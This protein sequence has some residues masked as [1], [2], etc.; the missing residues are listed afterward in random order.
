MSRLRSRVKIPRT[1]TRVVLLLALVFGVA[2]TFVATVGGSN[3]Y[4]L[5][6]WNPGKIID[7]ATFYDTS[8]FSSVDAIQSFLN[9]KTP[10]CDTWGTQ[11]SE[12][13]GGT[14][15]QYAASRGWHGPPYVCLQNYH[16]NPNTHETSFERGGAGFEGGISAAQIIW[17]VSHEYGI[18]PQVLLVT[19]KKEQGSLYTDSW[20][21]KSQYRYA[22]G[23]GCPDTGPNNSANC[24]DNYAGLYNQLR[25]AAYQFK[26][27][28]TYPDQYGYRAGRSNY[29]Q[30]S[31][32]ASCGGGWVYIENQ[33]T[34]GLYNYTPYQ[35]NSGAI[36]AYPGTAPCGAYGNRNFW[37]FFDEWFGGQYSYTSEKNAITARYQALGSS[38]LGS[39][40]DP[41]YCYAKDGDRW[42][43][44]KYEKGYILSGKYGAWESYGDIRGRWEALNFERGVLGY[45][46]DEV[47]CYVKNGDNWCVQRYEGGYII[48]GK[49]G[50]WESYGDIR[51][52]WADLGYEN[53]T[54]GYPREGVY[55][56]TNNGDR[57]CVQR[58][59]K[60]YI[61]SGKYGAWES[62]GDIRGRW[63]ALNFERGTLGYPREGVY[64][65]TKDGDNKCVQRYEG[66]YIISGKHGAWESHGAIRQRWA[67]LGYENGTLG[68]PREGVYCYTN[69]GDNWCVQRYDNGYILSGKYGAWESH[70]AIRGRWEALNF[71]R[72]VLGYPREG[73]FCYVKRGDNWCVQ[74]YEHG[75]IISG[76]Y[77]AWESYGDMRQ[78]W[79]S[80]GY[81][82]GVLGY[83]T[84]GVTVVPSGLSQ[85]YEGGTLFYRTST[86]SVEVTLK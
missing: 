33:A 48:S 49:Y 72:G 11:Q 83:P 32:D 58:Y 68:Y 60:G 13:G 51:G 17:N 81:E 39:A 20:P 56:Y 62:Y 45:P 43:V 2:T 27:Y 54:L 79:A 19:L 23:Y 67:D 75:Y 64:C 85:T 18:N 53:G 29:I 42:C 35:P 82:N 3:T 12:Y 80:L 25:L 14:R 61:L 1:L 73:V 69:N 40:Q 57:W 50:T 77:G 15:A 66:G 5:G 41:V 52:R 34:A 46:R 30:Y 44:Q 22:M 10:S 84:S 31:P 71:E 7:D 74:R 55:C 65:Y 47:Y 24:S 38:K 6:A 26:R 70:G 59:E 8:T 36:A 76:K 21:L 63:E 78:K 16:E 37:R 28:A 4:A 9:S 86:R